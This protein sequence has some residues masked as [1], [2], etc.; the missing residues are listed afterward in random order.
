M[1]FNYSKLR[2]KI[3]EVYGTEG[4]FALDLGRV[5]ESLSGRLNNKS[6]FSQGEINRSCDLLGIDKKDISEYFFNPVVPESEL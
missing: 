1:V 4:A 3:K 5:A 2:G 6:Q